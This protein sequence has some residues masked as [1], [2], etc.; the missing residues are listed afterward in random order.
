VRE[1]V[2]TNVLLR[3]AIDLGDTQTILARELLASPDKLLVVNPLVIAEFIH[4]VIGHYGLDRSQASTLVRW[5]L[6]LE[7]VEIDREVI[8]SSLQVFEAHPKLSFEDA[9]LAE[10]AD[11]DDALPLWTFDAKL[12][13][14][15]PAAR[16]VGA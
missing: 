15:H 7:S 13:H 8:E 12:S 5:I 14:Q 10:Q 9:L 6:A 16:L 1:S 2:D 4:V 3:A 11:A